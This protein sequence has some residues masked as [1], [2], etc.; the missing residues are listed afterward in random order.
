[1]LWTPALKLLVVQVAVRTL[2]APVT[3][4]AVQPTME[5]PPSLK[6]TLPP[7]LLPLMVAVNVTAA[8]RFDGLSELTSVVV[9][10]TGVGGG[11]GTNGSEATFVM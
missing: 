11:S 6:S 7:G 10:G 2:P 3:G 9:V 4:E 1:M 8:P 5:T